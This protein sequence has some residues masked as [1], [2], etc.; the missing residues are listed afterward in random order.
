MRRTEPIE[1]LPGEVRVEDAVEM[2]CAQDVTFIE[3]RLRRGMSVLVECDKELALHVYLA[4]RARLRGGAGRERGPQIVIVDGRPREGE[5]SRGN[6]AVMLTQLTT[7]IRGS[8]ERTIIVLL[9]LDV[10]TTTHTSLTMEAREA[11][12]L[13]YENPEAVLLGFRDPSFPLP[14][15]I[16]G[17]FAVRREI[18][19]VPRDSLAKIVTQREAR[20]I[21]ADKF[22]PFALYKYVSGLNPVRLRRLM[23]AVGLR[24]EAMPGRSQAAQV[25]REL[26]R[27]TVSE[28]VELPN[29]DLERDIGGY[30]EVKLRLRE[31]L[32]DLLRRK[33][34]LG[35]EGEIQALEGLLPR[36]I[37][38]HGPPGTGKTYFAKAMATAM[39]ATVIIVSGP[40]L[41]S[42]W[43]GESEENLRRVF[44]QARRSAPAV[45]VFDEIDAFAHARGTYEGSGVEH[46]M[47][48]Q[49]LTEMDG[50]RGSESVFVVGTTNFLESLD[51]AL[52]RPGRFEFLIEIP[53]PG[54]Q[55]R[56]EIVEIYDRKLELGLSRELQE[57]L[58]RRTEGLA[59][60][61]RGLPFTGDH[62]YAV[63]RALK[64]QAIR[65]G[66]KKFA[67][68]D[69]DRALQRK[70]RAVVVLSPSEERVV[71]IH[72]A[73]H[74]LLAMLVEHATPPERISI[75]A[76]M[77]G[78][79]GYVLRA[80]R[81]RPYAITAAD[82][83]ADICVGLGGMCAERLVFGEVS[84]GAHTDLQQV[85]RIARAMVEE[86]GMG[87]STGVLVRLDDTPRH[88]TPMSERRRERVDAE[89]TEI[90]EKELARA[91]ALL[92]G[93]RGLLEALAETLLTRK[94]LDRAELSA[95]TKGESHG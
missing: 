9:H 93:N 62:I 85:N 75:A 91:Q 64:R 19:G 55:D 5:E 89:V 65:T 46:S 21:D 78:A 68:E 6:L 36:G 67:P 43:V 11:I 33:D 18:V 72:E 25:Y 82:M 51:G 47:V 54:V 94:V 29:V 76:D 69:I 92:T 70:T 44:R 28:D 35:S 77:E 79:L 3:E 7:A 41:K 38:F 4:V 23:Q 24:R 59:E 17:V 30:P 90:L 31:E 42:K 53:A 66:E 20:A 60:R 45:I 84:I 63:C 57:H 50:F 16:E 12:P 40:E 22:D 13:L 32:L 26:R 49:L 74:A 2:A 14:R 10:L 34:S 8:V 48:N 83:R 27:Q 56:R 80:A 95:L 81:A 88:G 86:Y 87:A 71:A 39:D 73:G 58:V 1:G 61:A 15:V 52:L 37:I